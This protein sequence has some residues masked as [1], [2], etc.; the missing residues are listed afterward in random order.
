MANQFILQFDS[1]YVDEL[2]R[3]AGL[4]T[5]VDARIDFCRSTCLVSDCAIRAT[6][7]RNP[8]SDLGTTEGMDAVTIRCDDT[9]CGEEVGIHREF[10]PSNVVKA[11]LMMVVTANRE[12]AKQ[13]GL[14]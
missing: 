14:I 1:G 8:D 11:G 2:P 4:Q 12:I 3:D 13:R 9:T 5:I 7:E 10:Y 6:I